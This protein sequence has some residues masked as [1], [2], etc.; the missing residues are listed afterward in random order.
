MDELL[1]PLLDPAGPF[2]GDPRA[3]LPLILIAEGL[4]GELRPLW[5]LLPHPVA[6]LGALIG[7]LDK[8]L[9]RETRTRN[10]RLW[11]GL[12]VT[13]IITG[14]AGA[15]GWA[16]SEFARTVDYGWLIEVAVAVT[17][18]A[19]RGLY[20]HVADVARAL[21]SGGLRA[22]REAVAHIVG[23]DPG[24]LD[25]HG[26]ARATIESCAENFSDAVVAPAFWYVIGG[27][28]A[29][30]AYKAINTL[31]SMIG[32]RSARYR[33]FGLPAARLDD[34]VNWIPARLSGLFL[35]A[36]AFFTPRANPANAIRV[37]FR[38][39]GKHRSVNAGW[40]E[41]AVAGGLGLA[42][43][44]PRLYG[45][46]TVD[47][48]WIGDGRAK[49]TEHDIRRALYLYT[50]ACLLNLLAW[51]ALAALLLAGGVI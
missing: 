15:T 11:R 42:L 3:L 50:V 6:A 35:S 27:L 37:A 38:D 41:A 31:D 7:G 21:K 26:V 8:R 23:R 4:I 14:T 29:L 2:A 16:I 33:D 5:R 49:A 43:A 20:R 39:A 1:R 22:G 9:N 10:A 48:P 44:G 51:T 13:L 34:A 30:A 32:H 17:L 47:D 46:E 25:A 18:F 45:G 19:Q 28:P 12:L 36:A 24:T 40:P